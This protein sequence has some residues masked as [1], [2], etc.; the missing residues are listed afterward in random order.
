YEVAHGLQSAA[1]AEANANEALAL[2]PSF[3][4]A[5][6]LLVRAVIAEM[7]TGRA[8]ADKAPESLKGSWDLLVS[9]GFVAAS[10][11]LAD[12]LAGQDWDTAVEAARLVGATYGG[13]SLQGHPIG[14]ALASSERRVQY[15]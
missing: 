13:Q 4:P 7:L 14:T 12:A 5:R 2:D 3:R 10:D 6:S 1:L 9:Q 8:M 15:A 11:A